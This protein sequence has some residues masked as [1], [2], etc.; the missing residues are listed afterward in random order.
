MVRAEDYVHDLELALL[1]N[2]KQAAQDILLV[3]LADI[4]PIHRIEAL[5]TKT[6][7]IIGDKWEKGEVALSQVYLSS[8]ICEEIV[9]SLLSSSSTPRLER[10][11]IATVTLEDFHLLGIK[12]VSMAMKSSGHVVIDYG[13]METRDLADK[14]CSDNVQ[15]LL[16]STLMLRSALRV[17]Q[18]RE[19]LQARS[20]ET[21]IIV[22][23]APFRFD[24]ELWRYVKAD[25]ST[26]SPMKA[27]EYIEREEEAQ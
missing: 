13:R 2:D 18:L 6:L 12:V 1:A 3:R 27:L 19:M 24:V 22:G 5:V 10:P 23:G 21:K 7:A 8:K 9:S 17:K 14:V 26:D 11:T 4:P 25:F 16:V 15:Y 20:C